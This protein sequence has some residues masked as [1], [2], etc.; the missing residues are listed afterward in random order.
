MGKLQLNLVPIGGH[1]LIDEAILSVA[2][3]IY[4]HNFDSIYWK[5]AWYEVVFFEQP[6][7]AIKGMMPFKFDLTLLAIDEQV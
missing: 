5:I 3:V 6:K 4:S 2:L 7:H 1:A